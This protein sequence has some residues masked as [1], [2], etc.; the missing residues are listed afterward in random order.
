MPAM[1]KD[2]YQSLLD[3]IRQ[4]GLLVPIELY[5]GQV[6]DGRHRQQACLDLELEPDY[7]EANLGDQSPSQYVWSLNGPRRHLTPTQKATVAV[8]LLPSIER[9]TPRG[10]PKAN[11]E[12]TEKIPEL[13]ES[14]EKA[15]KL[16]GVNERY[17]SDAKK[18][19]ENAPDVFEKMQTGEVNM[20]QAKS[21]LRSR[22]K[23][24]ERKEKAA[25]AKATPKTKQPEW[26]IKLGECVEVLTELPA[27]TVRLVFADPPYNIGIDYGDGAKQD[28]LPPEKYLMWCTEWLEECARVLTADGSLWVM[29]GD[30]YAAEFCVRMKQLGLHQRNWIK[31]YESFGTNCSNKFNRCSRHILYFTKQTKKFCFNDEAVSRPSDRQAIYKDRR[32]SHHGKIWDD[33]WLI[34]RLTGTSTERIEEFPTQLPLELV[35]AIVGCASDPGDQVLDPFNGSGTTGAACIELG[36]RYIGIEKSKQWHAKAI[37]RLSCITPA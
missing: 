10:R 4:H 9:E 16:V 23:M 34:P 30:E 18:I 13:T 27:G 21:E 12:K 22:Q 15:A 7:I 35:R 25:Q 24:A 17:V 11:T 8:E 36:R 26:E 14:R 6:I 1:S 2:D 19:K 33:V 28:K 5:N 32:A 3:D 20:T 31:W 29:I 37:E